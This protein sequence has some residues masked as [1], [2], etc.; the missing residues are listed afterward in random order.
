MTPL[1]DVIVPVYNGRQ[2]IGPLLEVF[3]RQGDFS[4]FR[5][6][7]SDDGSTD[8]TAEEIERQAK[9]CPFKV[10][11]VSRENGGVSA[12]RNR[13]LALAEAPFI[14]FM[15]ADDR[16][17]PDYVRA[18]LAAAEKNADVLVFEQLRTDG[19]GPLAPAGDAP[20]VPVDKE[21]MLR[22]FAADPTRYG[23]VNLMLRRAF[24][25]ETGLRFAE[26]YKY[27]EDYHFILNA[28]SAAG[29]VLH[30]SAR[31]YDYIRRPDSAM[32]R[33]TPERINDLQLLK[34]A[35]PLL[36]KRTPGFAAEYR[37]AFLPRIYWSALWQAALAAPDAKA[38]F[39]FAKR[40]GA[41]AALSKLTRHPDREAALGSRLFL[42]APAAFYAAAL[43]L[44]KRRSKVQKAAPE[45][46]RALLAA[47]PPAR[48]K[49]LVYGM[50]HV[51]G[52][53]E[54]YLRALVLDAP[55]GTFDFLC[56]YPDVVYREE[57][58]AKDCAVHK[59][60]PK[61]KD[62]VGHLRAARR[63][64][65]THPEYKTVYLNLLDAGGAFTAAVPFLMGRRIA[66]H[67]HSSR[68]EK[69]RLHALMKPA[70]SF[71]TRL[72]AACSVP[73]AAHMFLKKKAEKA[74]LVPNR[75]DAAAFRFSPETRETTRAALGLTDGDLAVM[76]VGRLSY[77][78]NPEFIAELALTLTRAE[79]R[80]RFYS[81][82]S[83]DL[84]EAF[85][86][87]LEKTNAKDAV[88]RLGARDDVP[89]LLQ[90][91]DV[92]VLPSVFEGFPI[93]CVEAQAADLPCFISDRVTKETAITENAVFLPVDR[94]VGVWRDAILAAPR[95]PRRDRSAELRA[96]GYDTG[97]PGGPTEALLRA[98]TEE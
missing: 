13:G 5:V 43:A 31:L 94:G 80:C 81:V 52:G 92:F 93:V 82:G 33:F 27:Y 86:A 73:A 53:I 50:S 62:P 40:T 2:Y 85:E 6:V 42:T 74:L 65:R 97:A 77:A 47:V 58:Q 25:E 64:L 16:V 26:G 59:I 57:L 91:A 17:T 32:A 4:S 96:K 36:D 37:A 22:R 19:T 44:G 12:A 51:R 8:G 66:V 30:T 14:A 78:K 70:L 60:P 75:I 28:L 21:A 20:I 90:A 45:A 68:S 10:L 72:P 23:A 3:R 41:K 79:P 54:S 89:A 76:H 39:A 61:G 88:I 7:F 34:S 1:L 67:S 15:D 56:D 38:F 63:V 46:W 24:A 87:Y 18:L 35:Q 84:D 29:T 95:P 83:G 48:S 49:V 71:M 98:L 9:D 11:C 55:N 69:P